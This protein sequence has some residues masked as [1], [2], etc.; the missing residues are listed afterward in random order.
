MAL[1]VTDIPVDKTRS[2]WYALPLSCNCNNMEKMDKGE[3]IFHMAIPAIMLGM[4]FA[5][6][7]YAVSLFRGIL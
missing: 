7:Y 6:G 4:T 2:G 5:V 1:G 3:M